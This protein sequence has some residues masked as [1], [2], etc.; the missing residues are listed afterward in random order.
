M[1]KIDDIYKQRFS[2]TEAPVDSDDLALWGEINNQIP[3]TPLVLRVVKNPFFIGG[4]LFITAA[5]A[6]TYTYRN[7]IY[8]EGEI[9]NP[10][11]NCN[12]HN[13]HNT[14]QI[15]K[16]DKDSTQSQIIDIENVNVN[17]DKNSAP[18]SNV[19]N[20]PMIKDFQEIPNSSPENTSNSILN[21]V[22]SQE[23]FKES[24]TDTIQT[25]PPVSTMATE[26]DTMTKESAPK[27]VRVVS[28]QLHVKDTLKHVK[29]KR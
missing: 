13:R 15:E 24:T 7:S 27:K 22:S 21:S 11:I 8:N 5:A 1:D 17:E 3:Q 29:R 4:M 23:E 14:E 2:G 9:Q 28:K 19:Q 6:I 16:F 25:T 12:K 18:R 10:E 26:T 20:L